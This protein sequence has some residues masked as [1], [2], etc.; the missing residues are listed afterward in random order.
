MTSDPVRARLIEAVE[1]LAAVESP[2]SVTMRAIADHAGVSPGHA[3]HYFDSKEALLGA[4][5]DYMA[6]KIAD[7]LSGDG[8]PAEATRAVSQRL[9]EYPAFPRLLAWLIL[10]GSDPSAAMSG[11]PL[12]EAVAIRSAEDDHPD[13]GTVAGTVALLSLAGAFFGPMMNNALGRDLEDP[14]LMATVADL[15]EA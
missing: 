1:K 14:A 10:E 15:F 6:A 2:Q 8:D 5:L 12:L 7:G 13:P 4:A 3:Y 11:H 9:G